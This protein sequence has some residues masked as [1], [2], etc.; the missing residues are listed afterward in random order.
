M[1]DARELLSDDGT[2]VV[3]LCSQIGLSNG[4]ERDVLP[5]TLREWNVLAR[6]IQ[7]SEI[8]RPGALIGM[9]AEDVARFLEVTTIEAERI[10]QLVARGGG[11]AL[12]LE[13]LAASGI[14][15]VTRAD[16]SY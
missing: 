14:W 6:K 11:L 8:K 1:I 10:A 13:Q 16:E 9:S 4:D 3:M 15:C 5:L 7:D 12:E 2:A